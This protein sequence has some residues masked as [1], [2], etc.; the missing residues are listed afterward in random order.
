MIKLM[1]ILKEIGDASM[2]VDYRKLGESKQPY[3]TIIEY[4]FKIGE[5][6]YEVLMYVSPMDGSLVK[7][8]TGNT[9]MQIMFG[10]KTEQYI[11]GDTRRTNKG[12]QYKI[13]AT[14]TKILKDYINQHP[15][16]VEIS[17]E[18]VKKDANDQG[19][20]KLYQAYTQ[21]NLPNSWQYIKDSYGWIHL[22]S[23]EYTSPPKSAFKRFFKK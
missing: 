14:V 22:R 10:L 23:P 1:D 17:Y 19:R 18:P 3:Q 21:K 20:E 12:D 5:D 2:A 4:E 15:E 13:M 6:A 11:G 16:L 7:D 9:G 8:N